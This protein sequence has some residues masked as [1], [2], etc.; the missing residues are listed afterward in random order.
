MSGA[1]TGGSAGARVASL[2]RK[3]QRGTTAVDSTLIGGTA[4]PRTRIFISYRRSDTAASAA[5]LHASLGRRFGNDKVFRDLATIAPGDAFAAEIE[6]AIAGTSVFIA[7]IGRRWLTVKGRDGR[8][9]LD[10]EKDFVRLEVEAGLRHAAS[11]I[12]VL[13][14]GAEM[15][16]REDLPASIADLASRNAF[17]LSWHEEVSTIGREIATVERERAAR[18]AAARAEAERLD[19]TAGLSQRPASWNQN[20]ATNAFGVVIRA[21]ELSLERQGHARQLSPADLEKSMRERTRRDIGAE[22][23]VFADLIHVLDLVGV[24]A[25]RGEARYVARSYPVASLDEAV[26]QLRLGRPVLTSAVVTDDW[27]QVENA[28]IDFERPGPTVGA[29]VCAIVSWDPR[30]GHVRLRTPWPTYGDKGTVI[31][32]AR[33]AKHVFRTPEMRSIEPVEKPEPF[34]T[35]S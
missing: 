9:R 10:D 6:R 34:T 28:V 12:P 3:E 15:P 31:V 26:E 29:T 27:W 7:L 11:V 20:S 35:G 22:G 4:G 8:R 16:A 19:L 33:A 30:D 32:T 5:H 13:V 14:D 24:K 18:E 1:L 2:G 17:R 25:R 21:M 23:F